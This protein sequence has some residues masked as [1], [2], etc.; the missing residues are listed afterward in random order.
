MKD[1]EENNFSSNKIRWGLVALPAEVIPGR[2]PL[3]PELEQVSLL[4]SN[5]VV[6]PSKNDQIDR[7]RVFV[8]CTVYMPIQYIN[9][10]FPSLLRVRRV[11][12]ILQI[13]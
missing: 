11:S 2:S 13:M 4:V 1:L 7:Y 5:G 3:A 8:S 6:T 12:P 9:I 10:F